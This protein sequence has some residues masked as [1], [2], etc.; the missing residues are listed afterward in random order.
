MWF[1]ALVYTS[2][3]PRFLVESVGAEQVTLGTD[4]PFDMGVDDPVQKVEDALSD[5]VDRSAVCCGNAIALFG[6]RLTDRLDAV[7]PA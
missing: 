2:P 6:K 3:A 4:Y 5:P 7:G 1:D